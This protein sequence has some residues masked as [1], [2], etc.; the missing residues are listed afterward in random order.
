VRGHLEVVNGEGHGHVFRDGPE[1]SQTQ[2][3]A[4]ILRAAHAWGAT[5]MGSADEI[6]TGTREGQLRIALL[7][8]IHDAEHWDPPGK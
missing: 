2:L 4:A 8:A 7:D 3:A 1:P 6:D 5:A